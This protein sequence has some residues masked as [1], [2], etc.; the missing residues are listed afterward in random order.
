MLEH[1]TTERNMRAAMIHR[2][3]FA[4]M[5][6]G[7]FFGHLFMLVFATIAALTLSREWGMSYSELI[8]YATPGFI[9][10]GVCAVPAGWLADKWSRKGM[11]ILF[12]TGIGLSSIFAS[13]A[14]TPLRMSIGLLAI[15]VFASIYH[16]VGISLV[17][18]WRQRRIQ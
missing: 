4:F 3:H 14:Q 13:F 2:I 9:A 18:Q 1:E 11:M 6:A 10:L 17:V 7:H 5:C 8:P 12:F 16:P 15:G